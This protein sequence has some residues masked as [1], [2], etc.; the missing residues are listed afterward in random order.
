M[1]NALQGTMLGAALLAGALACADEPRGDL[2]VRVTAVDGTPV[3]GVA[4]YA[5]PNDAT[6]SAAAA[7]TE[8]V[9]DQR[10]H[11]FVPH[12]LVVQKGSLVRFPNNDDVSHHVYSFS[13]ARPLELPLYKGDSH[14]P[15]PFDTPGLVV[16]GCNIHDDMLGYILVVDTPHFAKTN[17]RGIA[18]L[19]AVPGGEYSTSIFTP[20]LPPD[21]LPPP[22]RASVGG[23]TRAQLEFALTER[24]LPP[25]GEHRSSLQWDDY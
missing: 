13:E 5:V 7:G 24:L 10:D 8:A 19:G 16:L 17:A 9:M 6:A 22:R 4:V 1:N 14:P 15:L 3:S 12:V 11:A 20:R 2:S 23:Q 18:E 21:A 25:H